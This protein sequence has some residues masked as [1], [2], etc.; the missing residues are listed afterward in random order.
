MSKHPIVLSLEGNIGAGKS[1]ILA[2]LQIYIEYHKS[3]IPGKILF[4]KE[5][6]DQWA[7]IADTV[8]GE[9]ILQK[10]YADPKTNAFAFQIMAYTT[11]MNML[12]KMIA[13]N[14]KE[15]EQL[16]IICERCL[17]TD[18]EVFAKMLYDDGFIDN[19]HYQIYNLVS[20][21]NPFKTSGIIYLETD[22]TI[23]FERISNRGRS[24]EQGIAIDYLKKCHAYHEAWFC[25]TSQSILKL[26]VNDD[27]TYDLLD[28]TDLGT[29]WV[30][31]I[32]EFI[33]TYV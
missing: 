21:E 32:S 8:S 19:L 17:E 24:G 10:F 25:K 14:Q 4:M 27:V 20:S 6:V 33:T 28:E 3:E 22:P 16:I 11:R 7:S 30:K 2:K 26:N 18:K 9:T 5:P 15:G 31:Q 1:T 12:R 23:C 13:D 29:F